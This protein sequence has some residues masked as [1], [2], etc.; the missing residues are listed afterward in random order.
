MAFLSLTW[1]QLQ[2]LYS[3]TK[4]LISKSGGFC[5]EDFLIFFSLGDLDPNDLKYNPRANVHGT[6]KPFNL[7]IRQ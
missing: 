4:Y 5:Q 3:R 7:D 2:L 6:Y 1:V